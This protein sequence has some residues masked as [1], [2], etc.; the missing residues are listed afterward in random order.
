MDEFDVELANGNYNQLDVFKQVP[1]TKDIGFGVIDVHD[2]RIESVEE[3]KN[4]IAK[5]LE[6]VPPSRLTISPDCG[7]KLLPREVAYKKM[8]NMVIAT[9]SIEEDLDNGIIES[10][11][12]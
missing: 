4:R 11:A 10:I 7:M 6:I 8:Q 1:F 9:R 5:G 12:D 2:S 3:I